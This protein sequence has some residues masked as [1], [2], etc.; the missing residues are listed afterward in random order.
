MI[1]KIGRSEIAIVREGFKGERA[2]LEIGSNRQWGVKLKISNLETNL[3]T[4]S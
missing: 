3:K 2:Q 1:K 4:V